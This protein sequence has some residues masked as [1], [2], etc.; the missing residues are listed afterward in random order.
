MKRYLIRYSTTCNCYK[1]FK[2]SR[3]HDR[4][5]AITRFINMMKTMH[6]DRRDITIFSITEIEN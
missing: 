2:V 6:L 3:G 4:E 5:E 1:R